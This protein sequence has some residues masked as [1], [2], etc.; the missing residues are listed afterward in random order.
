MNVSISYR[1]KRS[2]FTDIFFF[3]IFFKKKKNKKKKKKKILLPYSFCVTNNKLLIIFYE[4]SMNILLDEK[5]HKKFQFMTFHTNVLWV[6]NHCI[7]GSIKW[8]D[9]LKFMVESDI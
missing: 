7:F 9:L 8:M 6:Q 2:K 3:L 4:D 1:R 5:I